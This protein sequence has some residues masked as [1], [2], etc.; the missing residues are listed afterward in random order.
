MGW[1]SPALP[2]TNHPYIGG[3]TLPNSTTTI[4]PINRSSPPNRNQT[5]ATQI[6]APMEKCDVSEVAGGE[7]VPKRGI[8]LTNFGDHRRRA[9]TG[10]QGVT[11]AAESLWRAF[12]RSEVCSSVCPLCAVTC[13]CVFSFRCHG[14]KRPL[15][16]MCRTVW[17]TAR[18][19]YTPAAHGT[20]VFRLPSWAGGFLGVFLFILERRFD[21]A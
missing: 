10:T 19:R 13:A 5:N 6:H 11:A 18:P 16:R 7:N 1:V 3:P 15:T 14:S 8:P 20:G 17:R 2:N 9:D 12:V 4:R 21:F